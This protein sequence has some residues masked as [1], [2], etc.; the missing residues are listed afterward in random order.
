MEI[1]A[2]STHSGTKPAA[3]IHDPSYQAFQILHWGFVA[4]PFLAGI[5]KFFNWLTHWESYLSPLFA[6]LSPLGA[7]ATMRVVGVIEMIAALLVAVRPRVGAY[8]VAAWLVGIMLNLLALGHA[9]DVAL[10]DLGLML[11]ALA[12]GRLSAR[13]DGKAAADHG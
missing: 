3:D 13:Y 11:G 2:T 7:Q 10:R 12:L 6:R 4:A 9:Y 1:T 5:D 8:V